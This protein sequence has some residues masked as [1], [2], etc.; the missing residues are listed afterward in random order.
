VFDKFGEHGKFGV[1]D[2]SLREKKIGRVLAT[3]KPNDGPERG[4]NVQDEY[5]ERLT[6]TIEH[7]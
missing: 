4:L 6:F 1:I 7:W 3:I 2:L 5:R